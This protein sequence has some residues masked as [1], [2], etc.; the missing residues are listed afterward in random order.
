VSLTNEQGIYNW[1]F[2]DVS[3]VLRYGLFSHYA[4]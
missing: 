1:S 4:V 2:T 3:L